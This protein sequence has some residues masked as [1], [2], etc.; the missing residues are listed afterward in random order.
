MNTR[1]SAGGRL[2]AS[3]TFRLILLVVA[4]AVGLWLGASSRWAAAVKPTV[5]RVDRGK[6]LIADAF[7]FDILLARAEPE[8]R[9]A[10]P[11]E[12]PTAPAAVVVAQ[13]EPVQTVEAPMR[14]GL[15]LRGPGPR[16][17]HPLMRPQIGPRGRTA[18]AWQIRDEG[19]MA[20]FGPTDIQLKEILRG[21]PGFTPGEQK[22][23]QAKVQ[24]ELARVSKKLG[25]LVRLEPFPRPETEAA[26]E[27]SVE[28]GPSPAPPGCDD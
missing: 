20:Q 9:P 23:I 14:V 7:R 5:Q 26:A 12:S 25:T 1:R 16:R 10:A 8:A 28:D 4:S 13:S 6:S 27:V 2:L 19:R 11:A 24:C 15:E 22:M 3:L 21:L 18:V 17:I